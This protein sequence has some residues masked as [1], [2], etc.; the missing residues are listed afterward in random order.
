MMGTNTIASLK[1]A[2]GVVATFAVLLCAVPAQAEDLIFPT[3][4]RI[5]LIP[6]PGMVASKNFLG[7]QDAEKDSAILLATRPAAIFSEIEK[8]IDTDALKKQSI[9][10]DKHETIQL[11][12]GPGTLVTGKQ[13]DA[14]IYRKWLL[15]AQTGDVTVLVNAQVPE[16][17]AAYP[18]AAI[19]AAIASV[20][21]RAAVPDTEK[22]SSLPF[23]IGDLAGFHIQS[24]LLGHA[25][26]L[27]DNPNAQ[28]TDAF[29][30]RMVIAAFPGGPNETDDRGQFARVAFDQ[31]VG[32]KDVK[33]TM[34]EPL[35][36]RGQTGYQTMAQAKDM[37]TNADLMVAQWLRFGGG[38]FMQIIG[39]SKTS[40]WPAALT[41]MRTVRDSI[42]PK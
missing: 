2:A 35:R 8:S 29:E 40:E 4:S 22:L 16:K 36:L 34:S 38:A 7:F 18:D 24:V 32:I 26:S 21:V 23:N 14:K 3:G 9:T 28:P 10:V 12:F 6:P 25:V 42:T 13:I 33:F 11:G 15:V 39:M 30:P 1:T 17:E 27:I 5:G 37:R 20:A 31:I 41:R 19:R